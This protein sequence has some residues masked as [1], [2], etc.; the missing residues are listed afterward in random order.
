M[1]WKFVHRRAHIRRL[2]PGKTTHVAAAKVLINIDGDNGATRSFENRCPDCGVLINS[3]R[4]PNG[5]W[6]HFEAARGLTRTKHPCFN[7]GEGLSKRR[8]KD[9]PDLFDDYLQ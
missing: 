1:E 5:G 3:R 9:T 7:R 6:G 4:M 8:D 2:K